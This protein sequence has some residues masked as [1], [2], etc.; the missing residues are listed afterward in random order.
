MLAGKTKKALEGCHGRSP[1]I[2]AKLI[3]MKI[4]VEILGAYTMMRAFEPCLQIREDTM[5]SRQKVSR[6]ALPI[7]NFRSMVITERGKGCIAR[8]AIREHLGTVG[9]IT[10]NECRERGL[11]CRRNDAKTEASRSFAS[12]L[13]CPNDKY[14]ASGTST[15]FPRASTSYEALV[16][17]NAPPDSIPSRPQHGTAQPMKHGPSRFVG[18]HAELSLQLDC[19]QP[20]CQRADQIGGMKPQLKRHASTMQNSPCR[21]RSLPAAALALPESPLRKKVGLNAPT[22]RT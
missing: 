9:Y 2:E 12:D 22:A 20:G 7:L 18:A 3:L 17:L 8:K 5:N 21:R 14:F 15:P 6:V 1:T 10:T 16:N 4:D 13:N 19:R 11:R